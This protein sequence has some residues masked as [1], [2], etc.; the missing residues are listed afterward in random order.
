MLEMRS[1]GAP[2][3]NRGRQPTSVLMPS[4]PGMA[5]APSGNNAEAQSSEIVNLL[6]VYVNSHTSLPCAEYFCS[7]CICPEEPARYQILIQ[8][9]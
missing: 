6:A 1:T 9:C 4:R 2:P 7:R 8:I 5:L 3:A